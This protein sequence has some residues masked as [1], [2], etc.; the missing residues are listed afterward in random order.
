MEP[1]KIKD[2]NRYLD[3]SSNIVVVTHTNPDGDAIGSSLALYHFLSGM[4]KNCDVICPDNFPSFL[5]WMKGAGEITIV[6]NDLK[7]SISL[8]DKSDLLINVDFNDL[9]RTVQLEDKIRQANIPKVLIDHHPHPQNFADLIISDVTK[10]SAAELIYQVIEE[11]GNVQYINET[12]AECLFVGIMTDTGSFSYNSSK[13]YTYY[14]VSKLLQY[15]I[16]KDEIFSQVYDSF[17]F[18]RMRLLGYCLNEKMKVLP[19]DHT[20]YISIT[21]EELKRYNYKIGDTEGFVNYP[22]SITGVQFTALFIEKEDEIKISFR[23]KGDFPANLFSRDNFNGG[24]HMNAAG[25]YSKL[26][27]EETIGRF[28]DVLKK[29]KHYFAKNEN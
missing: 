1:D 5:A 24:G 28:V 23:S 29:Y 8:I 17:S 16:N 12:V 11:S 7:K 26:T 18:E 9:N 10:S 2:F 21:Q 6:E 27:L 22:L 14:A 20:A 19:D 15:K 25:G 13:P 3:D 4:G